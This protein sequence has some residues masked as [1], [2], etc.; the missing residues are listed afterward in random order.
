MW[1][2]EWDEIASEFEYTGTYEAL[3]KRRGRRTSGLTTSSIFFCIEDL[4]CSLRGSL[5]TDVFYICMYKCTLHIL[6]F[7]LISFSSTSSRIECFICLWATKSRSEKKQPFTNFYQGFIWYEF[8]AQYNNVAYAEFSKLN[9]SSVWTGSFLF[10]F[11][12]FCISH[13]AIR[14]ALEYKW[15]HCLFLFFVSSKPWIQLI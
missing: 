5:C 10:E 6:L 4:R 9:R 7:F 11:Y 14:H 13:F 2:N 12:S 1:M 3:G 8:Y 15:F